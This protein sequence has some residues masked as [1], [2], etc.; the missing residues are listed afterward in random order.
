MWDGI[1]W[2]QGSLT[3]WGFLLCCPGPWCPCSLS[4]PPSAA[5]SP[6]G[7]VLSVPRAP[8]GLGCAL[9]AGPAVVWWLVL[10]VIVN[11]IILEM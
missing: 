11:I 9:G 5:S 7:P 4:F 8:L 3:V 10:A 1:G 2:D 6:P